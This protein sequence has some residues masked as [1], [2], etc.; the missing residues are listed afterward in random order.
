[1]TR[2]RADL[3]H[4]IAVASLLIGLALVL[5]WARAEGLLARGDESIASR[6][7]GIATGLVLA[8][9]ANAI[10]KRSLCVDPIS[11]GAARRQRLLR[12]SG[13]ALTLAG[14]ASAGLWAFTPRPDAVWAV[15]P[16][17]IAV[18]LVAMRLFLSGEPNEGE[19]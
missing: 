14:L 18:L 5:A 8:Y 1:M 9:Y 6:L 12:F 7:F 11:V 15:L 17:G 13:W 19:A 16:I 3:I 4:G 2:R 10:P